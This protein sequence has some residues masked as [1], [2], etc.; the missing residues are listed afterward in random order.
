MNLEYGHGTVELNMGRDFGYTLL[1][2]KTWTY[3]L[4]LKAALNDSRDALIFDR[5]VFGTLWTRHQSHLWNVDVAQY[6]GLAPS[7]RL[8]SL[9]AWCIAYPWSE[10][11]PFEMASWLPSRIAKI[12]R[13]QG[14]RIPWHWSAKQIMDFESRYSHSAHLLQFQELL[15]SVST[16][17][18]RRDCN[19]QDPLMVD[20]LSD[21]HKKA[22]TIHSGFHRTCVATAIGLEEFHVEFRAEIRRQD[23]N[24]WPQVA[25]GAFMRSEALAVFDSLMEARLLDHS[26][27]ILQELNEL[28][29]KSKT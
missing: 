3:S 21:G 16:S 26:E 15:D 12:R 18:F 17:G 2:P 24:Q 14:A 11:G 22:W 8:A 29:D 27:K 19:P 13:G 23:V 6:L 9:P 20:L 1:N 5:E 7:S 4:I 25:N 10:I 28:A